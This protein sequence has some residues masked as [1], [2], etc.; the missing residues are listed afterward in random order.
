M[1]LFIK[2]SRLIFLK[3]YDKFVNM[4]VNRNDI[5]F[6]KQIFVTT[7]LVDVSQIPMNLKNEFDLYFFGKT[8]LFDDNKTYAYPH[9]IKSWVSF[10]F[11]KSNV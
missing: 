8:M 4:E 7:T 10:L 1:V 2:I 3:N 5:D 6:L 9:D 11:K